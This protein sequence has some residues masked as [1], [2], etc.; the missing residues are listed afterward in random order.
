MTAV[1]SIY[2]YVFLALLA[3]ILVGCA[4]EQGFIPPPLDMRKEAALSKSPD[5]QRKTAAT[6]VTETP[7]PPVPYRLD[8]IKEPPPVAAPGNEKADITLNFDQLPLPNFIQ[9]VY[10]NILKTNFNVDAQVA[11]RTDLVTLRT[12][13][14][15][16]PSQVRETARMLLKSFGI[17]VTDVGSFLRI[18]PDNT[19]QGY[20]PEIR[21]GRALPGTP[22]PLRP[23]FQLVELDAVNTGEVAVWINKMFG[24][25]ITLQEDSSRNALMISGLSEDVSAALDTIHILDQPRMR[26]SSS[27]RISPL[28]WSADEMSKKLIEI[29]S[30]EG[31]RVANAGSANSPIIVLPIQAINAIMVFASDPAIIAHIVH[32]A[33]E[34]DKPTNK[35]GGFFT[36]QARYTDGQDLAKTIRELLATAAVPG[37]PQTGRSRVV[38]NPATNSLIFQG[39][40]ED[41]TSIINL[42]KELD[43]PAKAALIE[44]TVAEINLSDGEQLG[45]EWAFDHA[46]A[47]GSTTTGGTLGGLGIGTGGLSIRYLNSASTPRMIINALA[48]DNR[49][50]ILSSPRVLA[51]NGETATIQVGQEVPVITSQQT[52]PVTGGTGSILQSV[53]YRSTGVILKV[54]PIIH[55][56]DRIELE[57]SQ[58]VS[59]A[60][61]TTTGVSTSPTISTRKVDTKLSLKDGATV[62]LGGLM[63][64]NRSKTRGGIPILK[65]IPGLGQLFRVDGENN[66][67]T[68]LMILITPYIISD[69]KD[70]QAITDAFRNQLGD[71]AKTRAAPGKPAA[72]G[73]PTATEPQLKGEAPSPSMPALTPQSQPGANEGQPSLPKPAAKLPAPGTAPPAP[74]V[75]P[76]AAPSP[77]QA[78]TAASP[79]AFAR[80]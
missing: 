63:S 27:T 24:Q 72:P 19:M 12:P 4:T 28:F 9:V 11:S 23:I 77:A 80:P 21:R 62:M 29:L 44:V 46:N 56:G 20:A 76:V 39:G 73:R 7:K 26:G 78:A 16:T 50:T 79:P 66:S 74:M 67:K 18:V 55:A 34:L 53:Q 70:A 69:D 52:N 14:P 31:Y 33:Q 37:Q 64:D 8:T 22:L 42:L 57:I 65:D 51:R 48:N 38:V 58:E 13:Q 6:E 25:K 59:S 3:A 49:A 2:R 40:M 43:Q 47:S 54:K 15:Q 35:G 32:W 1:H 10:G 41:Y 71:W 61:S 17:A 45:V 36:Y 30:A 5:I 68:E 75:A 60:Q